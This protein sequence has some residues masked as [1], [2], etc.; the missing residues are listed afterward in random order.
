[1]LWKLFTFSAIAWC[2]LVPFYTHDILMY[3]DMKRIGM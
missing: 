2:V 1:M 3:I